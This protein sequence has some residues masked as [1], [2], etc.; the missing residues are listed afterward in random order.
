MVIIQINPAHKNIHQRPAVVD[1]V[2]VA[3]GKTPKKEL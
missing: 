1:I 2:G 3:F